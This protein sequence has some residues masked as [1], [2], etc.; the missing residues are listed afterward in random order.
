MKCGHCLHSQEKTGF[1]C[2]GFKV[3]LLIAFRARLLGFFGRLFSVMTERSFS[4]RSK[5]SRFFSSSSGLW[6]SALNFF[7]SSA[8]FCFFGEIKSLT[9]LNTLTCKSA[10]NTFNCSKMSDSGDNTPEHK[11][12][13]E[14]LLKLQ[15]NQVLIKNKNCYYRVEKCCYLGHHAK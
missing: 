12:C 1:Y 10:S 6:C 11:A 3:A 14:N 8:S 15:L 5:K 9:M 2:E 13:P 7:R 4:L